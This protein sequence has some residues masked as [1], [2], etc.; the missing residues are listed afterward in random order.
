MLDYTTLCKLAEIDKMDVWT[1][2]AENYHFQ[3]N[4]S[5]VKNSMTSS[6]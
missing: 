6:A 3:E 5:K 4:A 1:S 2:R